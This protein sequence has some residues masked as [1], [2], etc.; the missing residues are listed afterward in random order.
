[1]LPLKMIRLKHIYYLSMRFYHSRVKGSDF[2]LYQLGNCT[3]EDQILD[4]VNKNK[5]KL[6]V[7]H[8]GCA[9]KLLWQFQKEKPQMLRCINYVRNH[10]QFMV[11]RVL[12][13]NKIDQMDDEALVDMLYNALRLNVEPHDSL[14]QQL[15]IEAWGRIERILSSLMLSISALISKRLRN[16]L[17]EKA[18][19]L[20]DTRN[21]SQF[22]NSRRIVQFLRNIK[23]SYRPLLEKCNEIFLQNMKNLG[24]DNISI[25]LGMY[26]SL[27]FNNCDFRLA[28]KWRLIEL[29]NTQ[30][31]PVCFARLFAALGPLSRTVIKERLESAALLMVEEFSPSQTLAI[32]ETMA[33]MECRNPQ[34]I[35][36]VAST[37]SKQLDVYKPLDVAKITQALLSLHC[38][39]PEL[40]AELRQILIRY[41]HLSVVPYEISMLTRVLSLLPSPRNDHLIPARIDV[42][43]PQCNL[44]D[45]NAFAIAITRWVRNGSSYQP[46]TTAVHVKLLQKLNICGLERLQKANDLDLLL[47]ELKYVSGEWFEEVLAEE[48]MASF[49]RLIGQITWSNVPELALFLTKTNCLHS[50]LLDQIASVTLEHINKIHYSAT[51][52]ILLPFTIFNY[53]PPQAEDLLESCIQRSRPHLNSFDPH[54]LVLF[55]YS[56]A[57]A[58]YFP[59]DIIKTIFSIDF[60]AKLD[61][62]LDTLS[63]ALN[64]RIRLRLMELNRAVCL[65]CPEFQTTWFHDR[66]CRQ[67]LNKGNISV[68]PVQRQIHEILGHLLGGSN[69]VKASVITPYYYF[70]DFEC[71]LDKHRKPIPYVDQISVLLRKNGIG[72]RRPDKEFIGEK[73]T[74][75]GG[76]RVVIEFLNAK[77]FCK[78]SHHIKGEVAMKKRHL[79]I[80]GYHVVQ[81]PHFEWN[82]MELSTKDAWMEYLKQKIF[83]EESYS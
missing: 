48:T 50:G 30:T 40:F 31:D 52:A 24:V 27:Y 4:L 63:D 41:L 34:L 22:N 49:E 25:I 76:E 12:A 32:I 56:L 36:N 55:G 23:F 2:L 64:M 11:L 16:R 44:S 58:G 6:A 74:P 78:N 1:M 5:A 60:L 61:S 59:E 66:Y 18:E 72:P 77:A 51:Y 70:T 10:S 43:L 46:G 65:E 3:N 21:P 71:V 14:V 81:I 7:M 17:I 35:Q 8:V 39:R 67:L 13:E 15:V 42:V 9:I 54:L 80:L 26:Q 83:A 28:A 57:L 38:Q 53:D 62:Q 45:L 37:L 19:F 73:E 82:S 69:Y 29:M 75:P 20:L 33:E 47:E 68:G 79:E